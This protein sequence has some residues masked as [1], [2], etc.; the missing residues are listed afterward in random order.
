MKFK[1]K[2]KGMIWSSNILC[3]FF[4]GPRK[5]NIVVIIAYGLSKIR[6]IMLSSITYFCGYEKKQFFRIGAFV[7]KLR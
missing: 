2:K 7:K 4:N 1:T 5:K 3:Y 6:G